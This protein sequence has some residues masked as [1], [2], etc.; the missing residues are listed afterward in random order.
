MTQ[1]SSN[2]TKQLIDNADHADYR[3]MTERLDTLWAA[4][5]SQREIQQT[6]QEMQQLLLRIEQYEA[7]QVEAEQVEAAQR[8]G[9]IQAA[10]AERK[11]TEP[12]QRITVATNPST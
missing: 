2:V 4:V 10:G 8:D 1:P 5:P 9:A 12:A 6:Q 7:E 11:S 3:R